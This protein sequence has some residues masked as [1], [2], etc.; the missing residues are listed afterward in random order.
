MPRADSL[1]PLLAQQQQKEG[2]ETGVAGGAETGS[3]ILAMAPPGCGA[4][5]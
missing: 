5:M 3:Q 4:M 2:R 1:I